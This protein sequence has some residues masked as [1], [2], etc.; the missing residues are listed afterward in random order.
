MITGNL[1]EKK[2]NNHCNTASKV[3]KLSTVVAA[4]NVTDHGKFKEVE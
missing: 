3:D 1:V 2:K 4:E